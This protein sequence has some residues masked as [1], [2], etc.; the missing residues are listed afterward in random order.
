M[1]L[2]SAMWLKQLIINQIGLK[3]AAPLAIHDSYRDFGVKNCH[4]DT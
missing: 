2:M 1:C 3:T 4:K